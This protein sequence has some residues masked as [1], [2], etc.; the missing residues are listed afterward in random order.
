MYK[1]LFLISILCI[2]FNLSW[3]QEVILKCKIHE[4][5]KNNKTTGEFDSR[6]TDMLFPGGLFLVINRD[7]KIVEVVRVDSIGNKEEFAY[8]IEEKDK[9][10]IYFEKIH[11]YTDSNSNNN[12]TNKW[13]YYLDRVTGEFDIYIDTK[14]TNGAIV[15]RK[16]NEMTYKLG[17]LNMQTIQKW[18]CTRSQALF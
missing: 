8:K 9:N 11:N 6:N 15:T 3:S 16:N 1:K 10:K 12:K 18:K 7:E 13:Q 4:Y 14:E 2:F 5:Y 17:E